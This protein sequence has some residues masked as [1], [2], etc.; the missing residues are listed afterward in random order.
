MLVMRI[1]AGYLM[2]L[3]Q[4]VSAELKSARTYESYENEDSG[5]T[6]RIGRTQTNIPDGSP[7]SY[8]DDLE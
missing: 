1:I 4:G 2:G 8:K 3:F 6:C 7:F 5:L